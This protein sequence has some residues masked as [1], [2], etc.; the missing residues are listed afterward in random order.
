[1]E[2]LTPDRKSLDPIEIASRDEIAALQ[3]HHPAEAVEGG[4]VGDGLLE[5]GAGLGALGAFGGLGVFGGSATTG[6]R[7]GIGAC[8]GRCPCITA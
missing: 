4:P 6:V 2:D 1:M 3:F 5:L 8:F 7:L